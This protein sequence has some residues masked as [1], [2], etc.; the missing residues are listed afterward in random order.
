[1]ETPEELAF[2]LHVWRTCLKKWGDSIEH[3][4]LEA[5]RKRGMTLPGFSLKTESGGSYIAD[6]GAAFAALGIPQEEFLKAC[7]PRMNTSK[8][9]PDRAGLV[10]IY[11]T[12]HGIAKTAQAKR[13]VEE[14]LAGVMLDKAPKIYLKAAKADITE[15]ENQ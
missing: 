14:K 13:A 15:T 11:K 7:E 4:A 3:H 8:R 2:A 1:M 12:L 9:Y 6:V 5:V 10:D